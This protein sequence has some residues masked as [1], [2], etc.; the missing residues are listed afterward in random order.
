MVDTDLMIKTANSQVILDRW[1]AVHGCCG[2]VYIAL[3]RTLKHSEM[4]GG[5]LPMAFTLEAKRREPSG[6]GHSKPNELPNGLRRTAQ[7]QPSDF[8]K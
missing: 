5:L 8:A 2:T 6:S 4:L 7:I 3:R 1:N